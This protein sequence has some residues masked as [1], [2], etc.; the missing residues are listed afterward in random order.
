[1]FLYR[2]DLLPA[3]FGEAARFEIGCIAAR[4]AVG[5]A[6]IAQGR[7]DFFPVVLDFPRQ[8]ARE[9]EARNQS[10]RFGYV[11]EGRRQ[12]YIFDGCAGAREFLRGIFEEPLRRRLDQRPQVCAAEADAW[13]GVE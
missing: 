7:A 8:V 2:P 1:M 10:M 9:L 6:A 12:F 5:Q 4:E 11:V 3:A 13:R